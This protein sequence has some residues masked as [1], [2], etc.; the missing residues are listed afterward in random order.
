M[1][2]QFAVEYTVSGKVR[3]FDTLSQATEFASGSPSM[4]VAKQWDSLREAYVLPGQLSPAAT[5]S[6]HVGASVISASISPCEGEQL[7]ECVIP[8]N[9]GPITLGS[10]EFDRVTEI[11]ESGADANDNLKALMARPSRLTLD[12]Q[13]VGRFTRT[14]QLPA[15]AATKVEYDRGQS[16]LANSARQLGLKEFRMGEAA[17]DYAEG[18]AH[19]GR[20]ATIEYAFGAK[21]ADPKTLEFK[22]LGISGTLEVISWDQASPC[23][24]C[25]VS[26]GFLTRWLPVHNPAAPSQAFPHGFVDTIYFPMRKGIRHIVVRRKSK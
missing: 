25:T 26:Q 4:C 23:G 7:H 9:P 11:L 12:A 8:G 20:D 17:T 10:K 16:F 18:H 22:E 19:V 14:Y 1:K 24:D 3:Y 5:G 13:V 2:K 6:V 15:V 21:D